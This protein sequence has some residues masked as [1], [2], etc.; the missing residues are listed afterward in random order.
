MEDKQAMGARA[1]SCAVHNNKLAHDVVA[2]VTATSF[3]EQEGE[4]TMVAAVHPMGTA[5]VSATVPSW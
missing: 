3:Q 4:D 1:N 2:A 5:A